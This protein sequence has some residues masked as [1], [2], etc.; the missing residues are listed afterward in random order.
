MVKKKASAYYELIIKTLVFITLIAT[1]VSFFGV[2]T[3]YINLNYAAKRVVRE[4][5]IT[6]QV[7][8]ATYDL[9]REYKERT[10][11][12][13]GAVMDITADRYFDAAAKKIQLR[14]NFTV[15]CRT[16]YRIDIFTPKGGAG[17]GIDVPL[18]VKLTGM[19]EK[20]WK[21]FSGNQ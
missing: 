6:G 7:T 12:G 1:A 16:N 5:E 14:T 13:S 20:F 3:V 9:F 19:S 11:I 17:V 10:N 2:F 21:N 8:G 15:T 18:T 4:V